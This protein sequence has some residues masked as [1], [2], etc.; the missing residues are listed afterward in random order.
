MLEIMKN[1]I[2]LKYNL[3]IMNDIDLDKLYVTGLIFFEGYVKDDTPD[4]RKYNILVYN[5]HWLKRPEIYSMFFKFFDDHGYKPKSFCIEFFSRD[6]HRKFTH[7]L[8]KIE[9]NKYIPSINIIFESK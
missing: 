6:R 3:L 8:F 7:D 5:L 4:N 2:H 1:I 9:I